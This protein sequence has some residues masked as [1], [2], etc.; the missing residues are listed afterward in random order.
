[1][2][3]PKLPMAT[4][5]DAVQYLPLA[6]AVGWW[7]VGIVPVARAR[8]A[9]PF[10]RALIAFAFLLGSWA[11]LDWIFLLTAQPSQADVAILIANVR[12]TVLTVATLV[13][14]LATK[15]ISIGHSTRDALLVLPVLGALGLIWI[16]RMTYGVE[17]LPDRVRLLRDPLL[18]SVWAAQQTV[19]VAAS[20]FLSYRVFAARRDLPAVVRR[21]FFWTVGSLVIVLCLWVGTH[22]YDTLA[23]PTGT[24]WFSSALIIPAALVLAVSFPLSSK[25]FG[26]VLGAVSAI[27]ERVTAVYLFYRTGEPLVA[28][29]SSRNLPIE[30]EQLEGLLSVVGNFVETSVPGARGYAV[31]AM[32]YDQLGIV[33]VRGE[34]MIGAAVYDGPA[35]DALRGELIRSLRSLEERY[36]RNLANWEEATKVAE[37]AAEEL[38]KFLRNPVKASGSA[39]PR[40]PD[41][42]LKSG[43]SS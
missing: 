23:Q 33:A 31:T 29:A 43:G 8:L 16:G 26:E 18:Y 1:L 41:T 20:I 4:T 2:R 12:I 3:G 24:P 22:V 42:D 21:R 19:Y 27:R 9:S 15:W 35:Y 25:D 30:A 6:S 28:L 13:L 37:P 32:R 5:L 11:F 36:W 7:A 34:Y 40:K 14:L 38:S 17:Q 39:L 10:E